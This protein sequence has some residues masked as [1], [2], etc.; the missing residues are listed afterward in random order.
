ASKEPKA[1]GPKAPAPKPPKEPEDPLADVADVPS[2]E[3]QAA[4]DTNK[5]YFLIGP[6][7]DGR[8]PAQGYGLAVILPGGDG[9]ADFNPLVR[10]VFKNA[11]PEGYVA[12]QPV[13]V[14]WTPD[15]R[16][17]WP[18]KTNPVAGMK[19]GTE[20]FIEAVIE[21]VAK[22]NKIDRTRV[23]TLAWS[24]SGPAAYATS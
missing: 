12:A 11:L 17:V 23:F 20:E 14:K 19:F 8:P 2:R 18:T 10:R 22:R 6:K 13:A 16:I 5:R 3:L 1:G 21:D 7:K 9:S 4:G 24:S 15:Q